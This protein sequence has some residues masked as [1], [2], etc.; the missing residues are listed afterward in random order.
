MKKT[1][2]Q[3]KLKSLENDGFKIELLSE[4]NGAAFRVNITDGAYY[5]TRIFVDYSEANALFDSYMQGN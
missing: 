3:I 2:D 4:S 5:R 1:D